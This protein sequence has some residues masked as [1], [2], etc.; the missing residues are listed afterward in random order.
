MSIDSVIPETLTKT[1]F[2]I[3]HFCNF[4]WYTL[5]HYTIFLPHAWALSSALPLCTKH[6][7]HSVKSDNASSHFCFLYLENASIMGCREFWLPHILG[8]QIT[9]MLGCISTDLWCIYFLRLIIL[10]ERI[11]KRQKDTQRGEDE[12]ERLSISWYV[13]QMASMARVG[14]M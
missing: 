6:W 2:Q 5:I 12:T 13:L 4:S 14:Q 9:K 11:T 10:I 3:S 8:I 7:L 1:P